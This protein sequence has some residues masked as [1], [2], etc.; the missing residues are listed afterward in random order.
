MIPRIGETVEV[1]IDLHSYYQ[2]KKLPTRMQVVDVTH[3]SNGI[4][5]ELWFKD[6]DVKA[7]E[8]NGVNL[9]Q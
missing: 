1:S 2:D 7:A 3:T 5:V 4:I 8:L 6:V 9:F